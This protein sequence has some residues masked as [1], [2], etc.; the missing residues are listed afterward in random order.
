MLQLTSAKNTRSG[1]IKKR[2]KIQFKEVLFIRI[3]KRKK[4]RVFH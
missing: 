4:N 1:P 3:N 2:G